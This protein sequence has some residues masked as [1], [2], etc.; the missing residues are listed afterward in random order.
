MR[1]EAFNEQTLAQRATASPDRSWQAAWRWWL[2]A[3]VIVFTDLLTKAVTEASMPF[4]SSV[5][6]TSFFNYGHWRNPGAA[7]SFLADAGGWQRYFFVGLAAVVSIWLAYA[8]TRAP[9]TLERWAFSLILGGALANGID[10]AARGYVVDFLDFHW[11]GMHWPAFNV[12]DM[13]IT[14]GAALMI[15]SAFSKPKP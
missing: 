8:L 6:I 5:K 12:A 7:F 15:A 13:A 4:L 2:L 3:L 1:S 9:S 11:R 10:R 14:A